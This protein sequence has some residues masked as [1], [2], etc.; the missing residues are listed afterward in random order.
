MNWCFFIM[1]EKEI[2][3]EKT[4]MKNLRCVPAPVGLSYM[5]IVRGVYG[6][7]VTFV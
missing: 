2:M 1:E 3:K 4:G 6:M 7:L 5:A